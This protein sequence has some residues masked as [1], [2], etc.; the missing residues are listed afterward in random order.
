[1]TQSS[2]S[3][4]IYIVGATGNTGRRVVKNLFECNVPVTVFVRSP[5]KAR[6][7]F[8]NAEGTNLTIVEGSYDDIDVFKKTI[9]GHTRLYLLVHGLQEILATCIP[10]AKA[11]YDAGVKQIVMMSSITAGFPWRVSR[12]GD[13]YRRAEEGILG[14]P[15]RGAYVALRPARFMTN[16][17][18]TDVHSIKT[19]NSFMFVEPPEYLDAWISPDDIG[20]AAARILREPI[21]KHA[22]AVYE[23][24]RDFCSHAKRAE[25]FSVA[26]G[27]TIVYKFAVL[28]TTRFS[29]SK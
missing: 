1:M 10:F 24:V 12:I 16:Q 14:I 13:A 23:M 4:R 28:I 19:S 2:A 5:A 11:A 22:D 18:L 3:E 25:D 29:R 21:E 7:L 26:L 17:L 20:D 6:A 15:N 8:P 27:R 9:A